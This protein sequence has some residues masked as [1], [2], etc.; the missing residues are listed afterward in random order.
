LDAFKNS[1]DFSL[2]IGW[3]KTKIAVNSYVEPSGTFTD[4]CWP[5]MTMTDILVHVLRFNVVRHW[6]H[7]VRNALNTRV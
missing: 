5:S 7:P 1:P 3:M 2:V 6:P 4:E